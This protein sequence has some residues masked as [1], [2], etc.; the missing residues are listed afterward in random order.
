M[1]HFIAFVLW[2][3][4]GWG[5]SLVFSLGIVGLAVATFSGGIFGLVV[6]SF[7]YGILFT[8]FGPKARYYR[9]PSVE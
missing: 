1:N 9:L 3:L 2:L 4:K 8:L 5:Y 7:I 6:A